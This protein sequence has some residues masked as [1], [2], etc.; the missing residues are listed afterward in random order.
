MILKVCYHSSVR[1]HTKTLSHKCDSD[2][3]KIVVLEFPA[4][5]SRTAPSLAPK[6]GPGS[7]PPEVARDESNGPS[8]WWNN[9][10]ARHHRLTEGTPVQRDCVGRGGLLEKKRCSQR[11]VR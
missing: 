9:D 2:K 3:H 6:P 11:V 7:F 5:L 1:R 4:S 10:K 8:I